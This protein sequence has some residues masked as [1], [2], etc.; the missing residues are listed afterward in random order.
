MFEDSKP[1]ISL[2]AVVGSGLQGQDDQLLQLIA[3]GPADEYMK[4]VR[5][6]DKTEEENNDDIT[7]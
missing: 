1:K 7:S 4:R 2:P 5:I 3:F 6:K